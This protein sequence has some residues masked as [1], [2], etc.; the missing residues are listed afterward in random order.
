MLTRIS[1]L[2]F[3]RERT[4]EVDV[5]GEGVELLA[6]DEQL[7]GGDRR[8]VGRQRVDERPDGQEL[9]GR[10]AGV[11]RD[12]LTAQVHVR[13][14]AA[15]DEERAQGRARGNRRD[16]RR[17]RG[18]NLRPDDRLRLFDGVLA[19]RDLT[20]D[21]RERHPVVCDIK[22]LRLDV[23]SLR[24]GAAAAAPLRAPGPIRSGLAA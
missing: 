24:G 12:E 16:E 22:Q 20:L 15:G 14:T 6:V 8:Q 21:G 10:S 7:D 18:R 2:H 13:L 11:A 17:G 3:A 19:E 23:A 1:L 9:V 5:A 4:T